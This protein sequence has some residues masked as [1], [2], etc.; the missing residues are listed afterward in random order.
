MTKTMMNGSAVVVGGAGGIGKYIVRR[1]C[2]AGLDVIVVGRN[3]QALDELAGQSK[4]RPCI[5][6]IACDTS[7]ASIGEMIEHTIEWLSIQQACPLPA[8]CSMRRRRC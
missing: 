4:I 5:A 7:I 3:K 1:L 2:D 6:D 8:A